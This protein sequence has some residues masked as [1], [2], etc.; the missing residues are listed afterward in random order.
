MLTTFSLAGHWLEMRSRF[1]T[2]RAVEALLKHAPSTARVKRQGE[3]KEIPLE[4]IVIDDE[5]VV[6]SGARASRRGNSHRRGHRCRGR[7]G[8]RI[9]REE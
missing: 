7:N 6:R 5:V 2:G 3:E 4:E 9:A 8:G 1:A